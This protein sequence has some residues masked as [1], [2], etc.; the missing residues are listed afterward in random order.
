MNK[1][2]FLKKAA[3][4]G[5]GGIAGLSAIGSPSEFYPALPTDGGAADDENFWKQVR[6]MYKLKARLH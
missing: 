3:L 6:G 4:L 2:T 1:R 5:V